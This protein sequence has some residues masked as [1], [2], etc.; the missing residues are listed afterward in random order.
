[1]TAIVH[2][3]P[4]AG[5]ARDLISGYG[6]IMCAERELRRRIN[7]IRQGIAAGPGLRSLLDGHLRQV[8]EVI[9]LL[10]RTV[11]K[12]PRP[13]RFRTLISPVRAALA[14]PRQPGTLALASELLEKQR[15]L[16]HGFEALA[17]V[18]G[19]R[20]RSEA[21][22]AAVQS[23]E[24]MAIE[25]VDLIHGT[26]ELPVARPIEATVAR[27]RWWQRLG[28]QVRAAIAGAR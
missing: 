8:E 27:H 10:E 16:L 17:F 28:R 11:A 25:L 24:S 3:D 7:D 2:L 26:G 19:Q 13:S 12:L 23:H 14:R 18:R 6:T 20:V 4:G 22:L 5:A 15:R 21:L 1:M 9:L